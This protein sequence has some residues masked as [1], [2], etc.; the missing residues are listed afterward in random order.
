MS[1][2]TISYR[3]DLDIRNAD[4][5]PAGLRCRYLLCLRGPGA[6]LIAKGWHRRMPRAKSGEVVVVFGK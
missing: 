4:A 6:V 5:L 1:K 2:Q 3:R